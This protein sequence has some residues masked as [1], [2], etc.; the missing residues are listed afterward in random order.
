M[1]KFLVTKEAASAFAS[2]E[3]TFPV[4][5]DRTVELP[6]G[7]LAAEL[8]GDGIIKPMSEVDPKPAKPET[9]LEKVEEKVEEVAE[10]VVEKVKRTPKAK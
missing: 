7:P 3:G 6:D 1:T 5:P 2:G 9:I 10:E 4:A 8:L